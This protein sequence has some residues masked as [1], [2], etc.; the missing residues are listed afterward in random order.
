MLSYIELCAG[1]GGTRLGLQ[2]LG[3]RCLFACDADSSAAAGHRRAFGDCNE[4]DVEDIGAATIPSYD[5]LVAG[6]PCQPFSSSGNRLGF[7]HR[8]GNVFSFIEGFL[9]KTNPRFVL[10]ENVRG[11]LSNRGGHSMASVLKALTDAGYYAE[12]CVINSLSY[13]IPQDRQ[14]LFILATRVSSNSKSNPFWRSNI[15]SMAPGVGSVFFHSLF[16]SSCKLI[17]TAREGVLSQ[18]LEETEPRVGRSLVGKSMPFSRYGQ[19]FRDRFITTEIEHCSSGSYHMSLGEICCPGLDEQEAVRSVRFWGHS[20]TTRPYSKVLPVSHCI[21]TNIGAGPTFC[22]PISKIKGPSQEREVLKFANWSRKQDGSLIFR[23][24]PE[25]ALLLFDKEPTALAAGL[26]GSGAGITK[27]YV[28]I[29]NMVV[30]CV[31]QAVGG[32]LESIAAQQEGE[33]VSHFQSNEELP[34]TRRP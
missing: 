1:L 34:L 17:G 16:S 5:V 9:L 24:T 20:G 18:I 32:C 6:F 28:L 33:L 7:N 8:K 30:P 27:Q 22:V 23:L 14:R 13:Q 12:W 11:M 21:G 3:W 26:A 10:F 15:Q 2:R 29:G 25:R 4:M 31:A 19:A